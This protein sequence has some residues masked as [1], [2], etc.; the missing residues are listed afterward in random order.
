MTIA[1]IPDTEAKMKTAGKT[2]EYVI[3]PGAGHGFMR[4]GDDPEGSAE[5]KAA[6][7]EAWK[8]IRKILASL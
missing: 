1:G 5:N 6:R 4:Q 8:R 7:D 3:Y 2:Y